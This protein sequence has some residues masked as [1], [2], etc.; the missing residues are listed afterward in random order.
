M[1]EFIQHWH[2]MVDGNFK[3]AL[4][5]LCEHVSDGCRHIEEFGF[6]VGNNVQVE[7]V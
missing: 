7:T 3:W 6:R 1:Y 5:A 2:A 4:D